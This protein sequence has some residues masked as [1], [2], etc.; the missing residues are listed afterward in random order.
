M[1]KQLV[2]VGV[3]AA[4]LCLLALLLVGVSDTEA[5]RST[6]SGPRTADGKPNLNGIW[7]AMSGANWDLEPHP[8][9]AGPPQFG[10]MFS[11]PGG[12]G[13]V[14]GGTIPYKPEAL[15][16][17]KANL[18]TR[19]TGDPEAKCY[20]PGVPRFVYLPYPFQIVQSPRTVVMASE[21]AGAVRPI[22]L[23]APKEPPVDS[24]MGLSNGR[25]DGDTLVVEVTGQNGQTWL[26]RA[27]NFASENVKVVERFT[28]ASADRLMYE[29]TIEDAT[30]FTKPWKISM[31][32][33]RRAET[34]AQLLEFKCVDFAE[35]LLYGHLS[36]KTTRR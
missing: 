34:N 8:S 13:V 27:G 12:L 3:G 31:P 23:G 29:A 16:K 36:K 19:W 26:D 11:V 28:P 1:R 24:W 9:Q 14:E 21:F 20:L 7:Q 32:L 4:A 10:A 2:G 35:E 22:N 33:Y 6:F 25:W 18:A 17:K 30:V 15:A 5:Q